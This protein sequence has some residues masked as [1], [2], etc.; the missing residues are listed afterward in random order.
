[1]RSYYVKENPIG[2]VV[3]EILRY[4]QRHR[5]TDT[6]TDKQTS[7]YFIIRISINRSEDRAQRLYED[8][9]NPQ[10]DNDDDKNSHKT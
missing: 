10:Q 3:S 4:K 7:I 2:S 9:E 5:Q 6:Q 1:M 8:S